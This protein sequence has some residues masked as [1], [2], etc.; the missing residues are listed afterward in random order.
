MAEGMISNRVAGCHD[1]AHDLWL[2]FCKFPDHEECGTHSVLGKYLK[3]L[4][5]MPI[6][7]AIVEGK[8]EFARSWRQPGKCG[9]IPLPGGRHGLVTRSYRSGSSRGAEHIFQH[10][11]LIVV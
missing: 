1:L 11:E 4:Q 10:R 3:K 8:R 2:L 5:G 7:R 9:P 6:V